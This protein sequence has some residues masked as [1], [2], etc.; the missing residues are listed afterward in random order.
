MPPVLLSAIKQLEL[1]NLTVSWEKFGFSSI[2]PFSDGQLAML[3]VA[4]TH[5]PELGEGCWITL[6]LPMKGMR[7]KVLRLAN[8][9]NI[10]EYRGASGASL[11]GGW[12]AKSVT[13][14]SDL[15]QPYFQSFLLVLL[16][17]QGKLEY[18]VLN[19]VAR[20]RW[21]EHSRVEIARLLALPMQMPPRRPMLSVADIEQIA[22][23]AGVRMLDPND[24]I[25]KADG[26][27]V[28][29]TLD[30]SFALS[31]GILSKPGDKAK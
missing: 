28:E 25:I 13:K 18:Y 5:H 9:L 19:M 24:P 6:T 22:K 21:I 29:G 10:E 16:Y 11:I 26:A 27:W 3:E 8:I 4:C 20:A 14:E 7:V 12:T 31:K 2:L 30:L 17:G 15:S 23:E 1:L